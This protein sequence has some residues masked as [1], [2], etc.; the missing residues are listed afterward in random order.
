MACIPASLYMNDMMECI[1]PGARVGWAMTPSLHRCWRAIGQLPFSKHGTSV[2][3]V[4]LA[5][6]AWALWTHVHVDGRESVIVVT[7]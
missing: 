6:V 7:L 3:T 2:A 4:N 5:R 1:V